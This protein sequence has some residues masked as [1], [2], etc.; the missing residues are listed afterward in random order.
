MATRL[1]DFY[2]VLEITDRRCSE[3]EVKAAYKKAALKWHPDRNMGRAEVAT[4]RFKEVRH[5]YSVLS[6]KNERKWYDDHREEILRGG[7]G[8]GDVSDD[9][10]N[11]V[12]GS[13]GTRA[14]ARR[15]PQGPNVMV[16]YARSVYADYDD[17]PKGFYTV[18]TGLFDEL[19]RL[20]REW[21]YRDA[22]N[23]SGPY[24]A[25]PPFRKANA[26]ANEVLAFY[27]HW[28][29]FVSVR[30]FAECD[31]YNP[32]D[33]ENRRIRRAMEAENARFRKTERSKMQ[34]DIRDLAA[35]L[36]KRDP[37]IVEIAKQQKLDA[38]AAELRK[39]QEKARAKE[40]FAAAR[41]AWRQEEAAAL[42][43][44]AE[45]E[46]RNGYHGPVRLADEDSDDDGKK[47][48]K[49]KKGGKK[50]KAGNKKATASSNNSSSSGGGVAAGGDSGGDGSSF[51]DL[52]GGNEAEGTVQNGDESDQDEREEE[53]EEE[54]EPAFYRCEICSGKDFKSKSQYDNHLNSK[55][56][57]KKIAEFV[58]LEKQAERAAAKAAKTAKAHPTKT[59]PH[60]GGGDDSDDSSAE[61]ESANE[62]LS[63]TSAQTP[64]STT[65]TTRGHDATEATTPDNTVVFSPSG[66]GVNSDSDESSDDDFLERLAAQQA[67]KKKKKQQKGQLGLARG[68]NAAAPPPTEVDT[69]RDGD[70]DDETFAAKATSEAVAEDAELAEALAAS[71]NTGSSPRDSDNSNETTAAGAAGASAGRNGKVLVDANTSS[72]S[73]NEDDK[74]PASAT[75]PLEDDEEYSIINTAEAPAK[76][77][78]GKKGKAN[79]KAAGGAGAASGADGGFQ[80]RGCSLAFM[81]R[82]ALF[83][84]LE[85][86]GHA[87][88]SSVPL[89]PGVSTELKSKEKKKKTAR[90]KERRSHCG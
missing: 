10:D 12:S 23:G 67:K 49:G 54:E 66:D 26:S 78:G 8:T 32:N 79:T 28:C 77:K 15:P 34:S 7:D 33:A 35:F 88:A 48:R 22:P 64:S 16:F 81:T 59:N 52:A 18:F 56:H 83:R 2:D 84:H 45:D 11:E 3:E 42:L 41:E 74:G 75:T 69:A 24:Q 85:D 90:T 63:P 44:Q 72:E 6:D 40:E 14:T 53:E 55:A 70:D 20:E 25:S 68:L 4:E 80:C 89:R 5:A 21:Y 58:K 27:A 46:R 76:S 17:K 87:V 13:G 30:S 65:T 71:L 47:G 50:G 19:D 73:D 57:K 51:V 36:K 61:Y 38:E 39:L 9:E 37:R 43:A 60:S 31:R 86:T 62:G 29:D 1:R 82:S